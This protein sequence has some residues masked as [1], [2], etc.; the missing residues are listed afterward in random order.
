MY[1][2]VKHADGTITF[3]HVDYKLLEGE[4]EVVEEGDEEEKA[5]MAKI[6]TSIATAVKEEV[7]AQSKELLVARNQETSHKAHSLMTARQKEHFGTINKEAKQEFCDNLVIM[8]WLQASIANDG[9]KMKDLSEGTDSEGGYL[10][11]SV[12]STKIYEIILSIKF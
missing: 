11:P 5:L 9:A 8:R 10:V 1:R 12:L 4:E 6:Q 7:A 2:K 3:E